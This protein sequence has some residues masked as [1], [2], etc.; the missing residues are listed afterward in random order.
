[1]KGKGQIFRQNEIASNYIE[2]SDLG[3]REREVLSD[4]CQKTGFRPT[5]LAGRSH[6]WGSTEYGAFHY[7]GKYKGK[8]AVIKIQGVKPVTSEIYMIESFAKSNKSRVL[9]PPRLYTS[10]PWNDKRRY[11]ALVL[12]NT[13][14]K[15][16][17]N[18]PTTLSEMKRFFEL[19]RDY[20]KN[21]LRR[22][23]ID[24]PVESNSEKIKRNFEKW[25]QASFKIYPDHPLRQKEDTLLVDKAVNILTEQYKRVETFF[26]HGHLSDGDF[27]QIGNQVVILSNLYWSWRAPFYD[28][29]FGYHWFMYHLAEVPDISSDKIERQRELWLNEINKIPNNQ[30]ERKLLKLA[31]LERAA[32]GLNL[33]ALSAKPNTAAAKHLVESTREKLKMLIQEFC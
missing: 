33:D 11:E 6:W 21:C 19:I 28:I 15:K 29:I 5:K 4:A 7:E 23:W 27:Y 31:L 24:K 20:R 14:G 22:P 17:V 13:G 10:V 8:P 30:S 3:E 18:L 32:A 2:G 9:R 25:R 16:V 1:V 26:Q 12:E